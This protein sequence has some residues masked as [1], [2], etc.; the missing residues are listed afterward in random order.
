MAYP[1]SV[2]RYMVL[3]FSVHC[4]GISMLFS[5]NKI[6]QNSKS[7]HLFVFKILLSK[8]FR[9]LFEFILI[10]ICHFT[11]QKLD[12]EKYFELAVN[13]LNSLLYLCEI[14]ALSTC[15]RW[16]IVRSRN[17]FNSGGTTIWSKKQISIL[18]S[19]SD[20]VTMTM[21]W[22]WY[23]NGLKSRL[24]LSVQEVDFMEFN[25]WLNGWADCIWVYIVSRGEH[26]LRID[27][28]R[29]SINQKLNAKYS[30]FQ[31]WIQK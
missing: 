10:C 29:S 4:D 15:F 31:R 9:F 3:P 12:F 17:E 5:F 26:C 25:G 19:S 11:S 18:L 23:S 8:Y 16:E 24:S 28:K 22:M 6:I 13:L 2:T 1:L 14:N 21:T 30:P 20:R 27:R 7:L